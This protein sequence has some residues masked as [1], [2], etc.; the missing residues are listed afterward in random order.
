MSSPLKLI[1]VLEL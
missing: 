1:I